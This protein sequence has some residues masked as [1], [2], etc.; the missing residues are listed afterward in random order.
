MSWM[1]VQTHTWRITGG[2]TQVTSAVRH[3]PA[4]WSVQESGSRLLSSSNPGAAALAAGDV[5]IGAGIS[6]E[7]QPHDTE[8][9]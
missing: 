7:S 3:W 1:G 9:S 2:R 4:V 8:W 6:R 5:E